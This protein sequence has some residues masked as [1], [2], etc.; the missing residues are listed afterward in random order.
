M[1]IV[2]AG[3]GDLGFHL[4]ELL[5]YNNQDITLIDNNPDIL[6]HAAQHLDVLTILG[7][8]SSISVLEEAEVRKA[9]LLLAVTANET[10]NLITAV[11]AKK[12]GVNNT[13]ARVSN[14]EFVSEYSREIFKEL[15]I[16]NIFSPNLLAAKEIHRLVRRCSFTDLFE[17]EEGKIILTGVTIG[18]DSP[19]AFHKLKEL[20]GEAYK[21][22]RVIAVQRGNTTII[23]HGDLLL[24]PNDHVYIVSL[25]G[26]VARVEQV[27][28][29]KRKEIKKVMIIGGSILALETALLLEK[30][31]HVTVVEQNKERCKEL[32]AELSDSLI[33]HGRPDNIDLLQQEGLSKMDAFIALTPNSETNIIASLT[34][35]HN[36]VFKTIAQVENKEYTRISQDIGVDTLINK[37]LIAANN[38]F[39]YV[40][41]GKVEAI[42]AMHGVD[43]EVIEYVVTK[44]NQLT[45][46]PLKDLYF[47]ITATVAAVVRGEQGVIP[48]GDFVFQLHDKA[49]VFALPEAMEKIEKLF[50]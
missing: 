31:Y 30:D 10:T 2:I 28:G 8:S 13:L 9:K 35:K 22:L 40:R 25:P 26:Q 14:T 17:F 47:P 48:N 37:K 18:D 45:R 20:S 11:L 39:R 32:A 27:T 19:L 36:G 4:A 23:P 15:G 42:T 21:N 6:E 34:A 5:S 16:E 49:I 41:K 43:A 24:R 3:A 29:A 50:N 33:I 12:M 7:D 1:K 46:K 44:E 38:I